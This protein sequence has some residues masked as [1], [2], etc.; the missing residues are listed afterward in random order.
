MTTII[1]TPATANDVDFIARATMGAERAHLNIGI[2]DVFFAGCDDNTKLE[3][4]ASCSTIYEESHLHWKHF[5]IAR[6]SLQEDGHPIGSCS[7]YLTPPIS[8]NNT[9][10]ALK[11]ITARI[12]QWNEKEYDKALARI[13]FMRDP[14]GWP[15]LSIYQ[16]SCFLETVYTEA[17]HRGQGVASALLQQCMEDGKQ[18]GAKRCLLLA[19]IGND[20]AL[21]VY[22]KLGLKVV[23]QHLHPETVA[24]LGLPGFDIM[25]KDF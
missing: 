6:S 13:N 14:S 24:A 11:E 22:T 19:A 23:G 2:W 18:M 9:Y 15:N 7:R 1:I 8:A 12:L 20:G 3:C 21:R 10:V 5:L 16:G 25:V 17:S 4:L